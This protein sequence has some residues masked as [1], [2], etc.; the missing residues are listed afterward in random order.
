MSETA[1]VKAKAAIEPV[2]VNTLKLV[3]AFPSQSEVERH[4]GIPRRNICRDLR[5]A[6]GR[7]LALC[8]VVKPLIILK[9]DSLVPVAKPTFVDFKF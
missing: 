7:V 3:A 8:R 2:D 5:Q 4:T 9:V 1:P 6:R